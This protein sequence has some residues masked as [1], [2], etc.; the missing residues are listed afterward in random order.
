MNYAT[1]DIFDPIA[2]EKHKKR[3]QDNSVLEEAR[4]HTIMKSALNQ[5]FR[6]S[7]NAM[8]SHAFGLWLDQT[9][10]KVSDATQYAKKGTTDKLEQ[11]RLENVGLRDRLTRLTHEKEAHD[12]KREE[13]KIHSKS[14]IEEEEDEVRN[15]HTRLKLRAMCSI[16][17]NKSL[18]SPFYQ[19]KAYKNFIDNKRNLMSKLPTPRRKQW[20]EKLADS[21]YDH[22]YQDALAILSTSA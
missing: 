4:K 1:S 11:L 14:K 7:K 22:F 6:K 3:H 9:Q 20:W 2:D 10:F 12:I 18:R 16:L 13:F 19:I 8:L 5:M 17:L 15:C 21:Q